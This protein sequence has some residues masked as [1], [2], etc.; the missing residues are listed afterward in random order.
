[1]IEE[2]IVLILWIRVK[3]VQQ[4]ARRFRSLIYGHMELV[5]WIWA[6]GKVHHLPDGCHILTEIW[7]RLFALFLSFPHFRL[8]ALFS[9]IFPVLITQLN[10]PNSNFFTKGLCGGESD[11]P[12]MRNSWYNWIKCIFTC[13]AKLIR[14]NIEIYS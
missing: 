13:G 11:K 1:M 9:R 3:I 5:W 10:F 4:R 2:V 14:A 7:Q 8:F 6:Q 12:G